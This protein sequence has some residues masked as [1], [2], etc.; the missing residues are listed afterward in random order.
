V[1]LE[2]FLVVLMQPLAAI[3]QQT[4]VLYR[5]SDTRAETYAGRVARINEDDVLETGQTD[6]RPML[7]VLR[8][9]R[10]GTLRPAY[11]S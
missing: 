6:T 4:H 1:L 8:Y 2:L 10:V 9:G 11:T 5:S 3:L 7:Y